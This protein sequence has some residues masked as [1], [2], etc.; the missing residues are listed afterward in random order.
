MLSL[1]GCQKQEIEKNIIVYVDLVGD[2]WHPG[3]V[4]FLRQAKAL[5]DHLI[6]GV[7][8]D[9]DAASYNQRQTIMTLNERCEMVRSCKYVDQVIPGCP[10]RITDELIDQLHLD[11]V[12]HGDDYNN[13]TLY[14]YYQP[15]IDRGILRIVRSTPD[16]STTE[17]V[18]RVYDRAQELQSTQM[19]LDAN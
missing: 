10:Y 9:E 19:S 3:H 2:L 18:R 8:S 13:D 7:V 6:V 16:I 15:A 17:L 4:N 1:A 5:G 12:V 14:Y 11:L